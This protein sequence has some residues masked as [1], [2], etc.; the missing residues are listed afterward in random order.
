MDLYRVFREE[1][2]RIRV[3]RL[4]KPDLAGNAVWYTVATLNPTDLTDDG[5][6]VADLSDAEIIRAITE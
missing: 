2:G 5:R 4:G 3:L 6:A 1:D